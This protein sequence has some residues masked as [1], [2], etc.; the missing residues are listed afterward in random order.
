VAFKKNFKVKASWMHDDDYNMIV[1]D[2]WVDG[3]NDMPGG[4][5][6]IEKLARCQT[7][8]TNWSSK[9][10]RSANMEL[11]KKA[12]LLEELQR[13]KGVDNWGKIR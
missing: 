6:V 11:K 2:A 5:L 8:L 10:F 1:H 3:E 4:V 12:K 7:K 13:H 9:K